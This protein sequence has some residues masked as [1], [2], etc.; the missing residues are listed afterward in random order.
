M[1]RRDI[2]DNDSGEPAQALQPAPRRTAWPYL[3]A[4]T[5][6]AALV[7]GAL[8]FVRA[9]QT[10][11]LLAASIEALHRTN[12][13]APEIASTHAILRTR[14][15]SVDAEIP[16]PPAGEAIELRVLPE[17]TAPRYRV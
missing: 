17:F 13:K 7:I 2:D 3:T 16:L 8:L 4:A 1:D 5:A 10:Q 15:S 14:G 12:G 9:P 11:P 6:L